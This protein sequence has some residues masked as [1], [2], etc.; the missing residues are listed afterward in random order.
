MAQHKNPIK[1]II[2]PAKSNTTEMPDMKRYDFNIFLKQVSGGA[3]QS[4][5]GK[6]F[7]TNGVSKA[8]L[9]PKCFFINV[10][11]DRIEEPPTTFNLKSCILCHLYLLQL[12]ENKI[13]SNWDDQCFK[14]PGKFK[15]LPIESFK[16]RRCPCIFVTVCN[17]PSECVLNTLQFAHV[18]TGQTPEERV[19]VI[20]ATTHQGISCQDSSLISQILFNPPEITHLKEACLKYIVDMISKREISIKPST[21]V[22]YN[23]CWMHE[24]TKSPKREVGVQF[25][26]LSMLR[27][28]TS[29]SEII[30]NATIEA[31]DSSGF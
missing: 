29:L 20:K 12:V 7:Q 31:I 2:I 25:L 17:N 4:S 8:K 18:E 16:N 22:L 30:K 5:S 9:C 3:E 19:V 27:Y 24:I 21:K 13:Q 28:V 11:M 26:E 15:W 1:K 23:N 10:Q 6:S 14:P